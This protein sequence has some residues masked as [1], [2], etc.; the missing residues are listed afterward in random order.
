MSKLNQRPDRALR[1][2]AQAA[3]Q[4]CAQ[5]ASQLCF[6]AASQLCFKAA[7]Q[8]LQS[9]FTAA[10][11]LV[12]LLQFSVL[13]DERVDAVNHLLD[14]LDLAVAESVLVRDVVGDAGLTARLATRA[15]RLQ[16]QVF[17]TGLQNF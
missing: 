12:L 8:L 10:S 9:F 3:S 17:A 11:K 14:E 1:L 6:K 5:A 13:L 7:S 16:M 4:L 2:C 15:A